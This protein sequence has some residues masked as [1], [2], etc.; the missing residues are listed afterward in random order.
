MSLWHHA[1]TQPVFYTPA[2][3]DQ[4]CW[5]PRGAFLR[6]RF[7]AVFTILALLTPIFAWANPASSNSASKGS[8]VKA[9]TK[10]KRV[11]PRGRRSWRQRGQ[12]Q[13]AADRA[14]E[15][16][17]ALIRE[18]Y[19]DGRPTGQIDTR[20]KAALVKYQSDNGWQSKIVPDSR[21]LIKLGLG[22]NHQLLNPDTAA[23]ADLQGSSGPGGQR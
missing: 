22:P 12:Q 18:G 20:T 23:I 2:L 13:I 3:S 4:S 11:K 9:S 1:S 21:A 16:Q 6:I 5:S 19:L 7:L 10:K 8:A 15:I 14:R 17:Q